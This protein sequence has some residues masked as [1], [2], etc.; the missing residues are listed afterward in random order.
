MIS[1]Q[2]VVLWC[3]C[4]ETSKMFFDF[5]NA[6][7][8]PHAESRVFHGTMIANYTVRADVYNK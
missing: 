7:D 6:F 8:E 1:R 3:R 5:E 4:K 2:S